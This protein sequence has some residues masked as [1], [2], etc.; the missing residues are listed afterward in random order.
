MS[1]YKFA[2]VQR[3]D[4]KVKPYWVW[5]VE[6][7]EHFSNFLNHR[8]D[9]LTKEYFG[10]KH[11]IET[12]HHFSTGTE[13]A[14]NFALDSYDQRNTDPLKER[15]SIIDD[16]RVLGETFINPIIA[17][18]ANRTCPLAVNPTAGFCPMSPSL[19][20]ILKTK[21]SDVLDMP[22]ELYDETDI[23]ITRWPD[24]SHYYAKIDSID[25]VV[26][27][28]VKWNTYDEAEKHAKE[29]MKTLNEKYVSELQNA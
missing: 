15:K 2:L 9:F 22:F 7:N 17:M 5:M 10:A 14:V 26:K 28:D 27:G 25:V 20:K 18:W 29:Y 8:R 24:G 19:F 1:A 4:I 12:F 23:K 16:S 13:Y 6:T 11:A 21:E 3:T